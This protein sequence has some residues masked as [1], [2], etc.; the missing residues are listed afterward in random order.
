MWLEQRA[1]GLFDQA[2]GFCY[3]LAA[4]ESSPYSY[5]FD[6][7]L[8]LLIDFMLLLFCQAALLLFRLDLVAFYCL[9]P[10]F[11]DLCL[12]WLVPWFVKKLSS[13][14]EELVR[15]CGC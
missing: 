15:P 10:L 11:M 2:C 14:L 5:S 7:T 9:L 8:G 3:D 12:S 6:P 13:C 1:F 4:K